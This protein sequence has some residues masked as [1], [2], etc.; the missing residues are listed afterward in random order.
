MEIIKKEQSQKFINGNITAYEYPSENKSINSGYVE[1]R[2][3]YPA[4]GWI[5]NQV[6]TELAFIIRGSAILTTQTESFS[7]KEMDQI[8]INPNEKYFWNGDCDVLVPSTPPWFP[9][10]TKIEK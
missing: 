7:L 8:I 10:Q 2:G 6:C 5:C 9:E 1:I 3:R 4:E